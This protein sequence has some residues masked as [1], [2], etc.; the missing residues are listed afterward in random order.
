MS[1]LETLKEMLD[2]RKVSYSEEV[3]GDI[4]HVDVEGGYSRSSEPL[5]TTFE[6]SNEGSLLSIMAGE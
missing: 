1:D 3:Y 6:F 4:V 5:Y 2:K